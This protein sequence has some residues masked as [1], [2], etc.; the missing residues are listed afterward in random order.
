MCSD[1]VNITYPIGKLVDVQLQPVA[2]SMSTFSKDS[3]AF[4]KL[5]EALITQPEIQGFSV[6]AVGMYTNIHTGAALAA[7]N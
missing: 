2:H 1:C 5:L 3:S 7:I 4:K 6:D